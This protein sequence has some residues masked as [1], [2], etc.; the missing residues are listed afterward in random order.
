MLWQKF[1]A[2]LTTTA[3]HAW[4]DSLELY[5]LWIL[6]TDFGWTVTMVTFQKI[7]AEIVNVCSTSLLSLWLENTAQQTESGT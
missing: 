3:N 7:Q 4:K 2:Q 1:D 6:R 5:P